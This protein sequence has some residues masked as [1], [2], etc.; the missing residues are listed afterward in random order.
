LKLVYQSFENRVHD[1]F[2]ACGFCACG[3]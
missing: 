2:C 1:F 3:G